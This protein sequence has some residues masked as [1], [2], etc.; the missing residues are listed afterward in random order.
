MP[1]PHAA[2]PDSPVARSPQKKRGFRI[3]CGQ[4]I[5]ADCRGSCQSKSNDP[6]EALELRRRSRRRTP[7]GGGASGDGAQGPPGGPEPGAEPLRCS[8]RY[9]LETHPH[10]ILKTPKKRP[11]SYGRTADRQTPPSGPLACAGFCRGPGEVPVAGLPRDQRR[12]SR[13]DAQRQPTV[14]SPDQLETGIPRT[15]AACASNGVMIQ[16]KPN[17]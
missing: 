5:E 12:G 13:L 11:A 9:T 14:Q 16:L 7:K 3:S 1:D 8:S 4:R 2:G 17:I 6:A 15:S 10:E